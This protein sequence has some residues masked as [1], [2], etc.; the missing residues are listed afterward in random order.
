M[1][2]TGSPP[3][4]AYWSWVKCA[5]P[6][7]AYVDGV[8]DGLASVSTPLYRATGH[9]VHEQ[10]L[11][12]TFEHLFRS[13]HPFMCERSPCGAAKNICAVSS[14]GE[15]YSCHQASGNR[16]FH[17]GSLYDKTFSELVKT[18]VARTLQARNTK[19]IP[20][21]SKCAYRPWCASPCAVSALSSHG[22]VMAS[23]E[24]VKLRSIDTS[25]L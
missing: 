15:V 13:G 14:K 5:S 6:A 8:C 16:H 25:G 22:S 19:S 2:S 10:Y 18:R 20:G 24:I 7:K 1:L 12:L 4:G 23:T 3:D 11:A 9:V 17:L 21:C